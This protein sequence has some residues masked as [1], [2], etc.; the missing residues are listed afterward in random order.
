MKSEIEYSDE[1]IKVLTN[2]IGVELGKPI[3]F[4]YYELKETLLKSIKFHPKATT[5]DVQLA[6]DLLA[7]SIFQQNIITPFFGARNMMERLEEYRVSSI[8]M[9]NYTLGEDDRATIRH[10]TN[11]FYAIL[12]RFGL[13]PSSLDFS[14]PEDAIKLVLK[15]PAPKEYE[16]EDEYE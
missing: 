9:A 14:S 15:P 16:P 3:R 11:T 2:G 7:L 10:C 8:R 1:M 4:C 12:K 13:L 5:D 6:I